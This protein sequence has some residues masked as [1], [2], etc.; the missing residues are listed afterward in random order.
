MSLPTPNLYYSFNIPDKNL[1][2]NV[3][4]W[5]T[6]Y[7][8]YDASLNNS[9]ISRQNFTIGNGSLEMPKNRI[10]TPPTAKTTIAKTSSTLSM[11]VSND[12][13][14]M[15]LCE[16]G[17]SGAVFYK[18]RAST[19]VAFSSDITVSGS[20]GKRYLRIT[21]TG[22]GNR[23]VAC[24]DGNG[25]GGYVWFSIWNG[26]GF[27]ALT[28]VLDNTPRL[29]TSVAITKDG[30]R[31]VASSGSNIFFTNW[32]GSNYNSFT[33]T[34]QTTILNSAFLGIGISSNGD[35]I[36][37]GDAN[38]R[39]FRLSYWNGSNYSNSVITRSY[40]SPV[41]PRSTYFNNDA[42]ILFLSFYNNSTTGLEIATHNYNT[43]AYDFSYN[44][45][46]SIIPA[47]TYDYHGLC[48]IDTS[49][50][51]II[52]ASPFGQSSVYVTEAAYITTNGYSYANVN[53][54]AIPIGSSGL[55]FAFWF[56]SNY[57]GT[58]ARI[59]DFGN[60]PDKDNIIIAIYNNN[61]LL[62]IYRLG[63]GQTQPN[64]IN[65]SINDNKWYHAVITLTG[66]SSSNTNICTAYINGSTNTFTNTAYLYPNVINRT[67]NYLGR[68]NWNVDPQFFGNIDDFRV[69]PT[70]LTAAQVNQIYNNRDVTNNYRNSK[71]Y[72]LY[73]VPVETSG[74]DLQITSMGTNNTYF[75]WN[76]PSAG[77]KTVGGTTGSAII[78]RANPYNFKYTYNNTDSYDQVNITFICNDM[79]TVK[80]NDSIIINNA[81]WP[82]VYTKTAVP[83]NTGD[84]VFEF[85]C[86]N[87]GGPAVFAAYVVSTNDSTYLFSTNS[88]TLD[89]SIEVTGFFSNG[90]PV[91]ALLTNESGL[92]KTNI[93]TTF[94]RSQNLDLSSNQCNRQIPLSNMLFTTNNTD[95]KDQFFSY[96]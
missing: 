44:M 34:L 4:N 52:Y 46:T 80:V 66:T 6:G 72:K 82:T 58:W 76:D 10:T 5:T 27:P 7:P 84:N 45:P 54:N 13:L 94:F 67:N 21:I 14:R 30:S 87:T 15:V 71:I 31:L 48:C 24:D 73:N 83:I 70:V 56:R 86:Y 88:T 60:G 22:D 37:Y 92:A 69:Y 79:I 16:F 63:S 33:Q 26:S 55:S 11:A 12:Q 50:S 35:R 96:V 40:T 25:S 59:C 89:W 85:L 93:G 95:F 9:Y 1:Y 62:N 77:V 51:V 78:N 38:N 41:A 28:R 17:G 53:A 81:T 32:N 19:S 49:T 91:S 57:N 75:Y 20:G 8:V 3:Q 61:L 74:Y 64:F 39:V 2:N 23:L 68:S 18:T 65:Y 47:G 36:C 42:T 29:Y 90:Y 43:N